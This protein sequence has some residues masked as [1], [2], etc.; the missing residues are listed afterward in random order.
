MAIPREGRE[1]AALRG[2]QVPP[3]KQRKCFLTGAEG[4]WEYLHSGQQ[5]KGCRIKVDRHTKA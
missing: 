3:Q 1:M 4:S 2:S 5:R